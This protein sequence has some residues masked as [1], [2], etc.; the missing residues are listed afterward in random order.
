MDFWKAFQI[1]P[2]MTTNDKTEEL[3]LT[4]TSTLSDTPSV[5]CLRVEKDHVAMD[6][7]VISLSLHFV[8]PD[9]GDDQ[10]HMKSHPEEDDSLDV[11]TLD[12]PED[13]DALIDAVET[14]HALTTEET[15]QLKDV[16]KQFDCTSEGRLGRTTLIEHEIELIEGA[17]MKELPMYR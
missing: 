17:N 8:E 15:R 5:N 10:I 2:V 3:D 16:L 4:W 13:P 1:R 7:D 11:P 12:L 6:D 14:E 9:V